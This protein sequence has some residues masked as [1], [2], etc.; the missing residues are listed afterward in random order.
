MLI[1]DWSSDVCSSDLLTCVLG[2]AS[3]SAMAGLAG[4]AAVVA[5]AGVGLDGAVSVAAGSS[6][7]AVAAVSWPLA[8]A[9]PPAAAVSVAAP[10]RKSAVEGKRVSVRVDLGGCGIIEKK[11]YKT[12]L[13][14]IQ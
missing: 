12:Y 5:G 8:S 2:L 13:Y 7:A 4:A 9:W 1:S 14:K 3:G 10:D 11:S 6:L